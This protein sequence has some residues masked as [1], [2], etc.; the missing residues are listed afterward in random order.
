MQ[1][2]EGFEDHTGV[3]RLGRAASGFV[4]ARVLCSPCPSVAR[5]F[6]VVGAFLG[7]L[8]VLVDW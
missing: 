5:W 4:D 1:D 6:S 3:T 7:A 8:V 2:F